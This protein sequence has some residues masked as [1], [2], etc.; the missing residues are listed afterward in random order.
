M[1]R[2]T[3]TS[4]GRHLLLL[5]GFHG[6]F[7]FS[8]TGWKC[9]W[10]RYIRYRMCIAYCDV[11]VMNHWEPR[12]LCTE[13]LCVIYSENLLHCEFVMVGNPVMRNTHCSRICTWEPKYHIQN[14]MYIFTDT[15]FW[16]L[17]VLKPVMELWVIL[18][19]WN[20]NWTCR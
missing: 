5:Y 20:Y 15:P 4:L 12:K 13:K 19:S 17:T 7:F 3:E 14:Q 16:L 10:F 6:T 18:Q 9:C 1:T 2:C 8:P 11:K